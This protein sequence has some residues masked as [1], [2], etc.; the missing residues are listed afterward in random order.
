MKHI[1]LINPSANPSRSTPDIWTDYER[2]VNI[3]TAPAVPL[4]IICLG[5]YL[6][7]KGYEVRLIDSRLYSQDEFYKIL[8]RQVQGAFLVGISVMT[9]YIE[10]TLDILKFVKQHDA[11][12]KTV[13][14][15]IHPS[16][17][18]EQ[19]ARHP[20]VDFVVFGEGELPLEAVAKKLLK[21]EDS[22]EEINNLC[23]EKKGATFFRKVLEFVDLNEIPVCDYDLVDIE[24]YITRKF[25]DKRWGRM[26]EYQSSR[27]CPSRC[28]FCVNTIINKRR[29][30]QK[31][32]ARIIREVETLKDRFRLDH[33]FFI[34][35]NFFPN[36]KN[37]VTIVQGLE[38]ISL[39]WEANA[40]ANYFNDGYI[41]DDFMKLLASSG[42]A[43][44]RMGIESGSAQILNMLEKDITKDDIL[45]AVRIS[46]QNKVFAMTSFMIGLPGET[47]KD[48]IETLDV[49]CQI[50]AIGGDYLII[51]GP[52]VFRPYPGGELYEL[53]KKEGLREPQSFDEWGEFSPI[54]TGYIDDFNWVRDRSF[55]KEVVLLRSIAQDGKAERKNWSIFRRAARGFFYPLVRFRINRSFYS[56]LIDIKLA[57]LLKSLLSKMKSVEHN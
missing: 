25:Q 41:N 8:H 26:L 55:V 14:G 18:P 10:E 7:A 42:F 29:W 35:E 43:V 20:L 38:N 3:G 39:T 11:A 21:Q 12:I 15:G 19:T 53:C 46:C 4:G 16:L 54:K 51:S 9:S 23:F 34:D 28:S 40:R 45:N 32:P 37:V 57:H 17:F 27:G 31:D 1:I 47:K 13:L 56:F 44:N 24:R 49:I 5:T 22:F 48:V 30:R 2:K 6:K 50:E 36:K 52:H 33:I